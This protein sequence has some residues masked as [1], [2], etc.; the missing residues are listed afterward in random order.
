MSNDKVEGNE[1]TCG[2]CKTALICVKVVSEWQGKKEEKLQW[3]SKLS[4][5]AHFKYA[6]PGKYNCINID[7]ATV[8]E[9]TPEPPKESKPEI[10]PGT[11]KVSGPFDEA[12]LITR[13]ARERAYKMVMVEVDDY[14]KLTQQEKNSLGQKEGMLTRCL[15]DVTLK[16]MEMHGIK[17]NYGADAFD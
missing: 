6:G 9:T 1:K 3:Q 15:V 4:H 13:W 16:L 5:K 12:E 2:N 14:S 10:T 17:T 8:T 7:G 11:V